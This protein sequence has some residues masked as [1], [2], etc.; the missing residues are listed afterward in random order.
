MRTRRR[1]YAR[2]LCLDATEEGLVN[3]ST[4]MPEDQHCRTHQ[5]VRDRNHGIP[6]RGRNKFGLEAGWR[7]QYAAD[8]DAAADH[9]G[10]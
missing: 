8:D 9:D 2:D 7:G 3:V 10:T 5:A 4:G 1:S 6:T